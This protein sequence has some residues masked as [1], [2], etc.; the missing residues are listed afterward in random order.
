MRTIRLI[1]EG[2]IKSFQF[3]L[4]G[5]ERVLKHAE[6]DISLETT[7][8]N[9]L[10][11]RY[12]MNVIWDD[13]NKYAGFFI[14]RYEPSNFIIVEI[15]LKPGHKGLFDQVI[16]HIKQLAPKYNCT[17]ITGWSKRK[18]MGKIAKKAG[19]KEGYIEYYM[20]VKNG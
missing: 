13:E 3:F 5:V 18:G 19:F 16:E 6:E 20:E 7:Y 12:L 15:Y 11:G 9:L 17:K 8:N 1:P 14:N 10:S 4:E 2:I